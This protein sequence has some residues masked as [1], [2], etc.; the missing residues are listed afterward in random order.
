MGDH[1][2]EVCDHAEI[3]DSG[4]RLSE[5]FDIDENAVINNM[6]ES[7]STT[8]PLSQGAV[9]IQVMAVPVRTFVLQGYSKDVKLSKGILVPSFASHWGV[10]TGVPGALTLYHLVFRSDVPDDGKSNTLRGK[11]RGVQFHHTQWPPASGGFSGADTTT[12]VGKTKYS[13]E[14]RLRIGIVPTCLLP[15]LS[16]K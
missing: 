11:R 1:I 3:I 15:F 4:Q 5:L 2:Q 6:Q 13:H 12:L 9:S 7:C 10:V 16:N 8:Q 14:D